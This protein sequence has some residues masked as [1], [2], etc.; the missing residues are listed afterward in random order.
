MQSSRLLPQQI[1]N[2]VH[3]EWVSSVILTCTNN[4][5]FKNVNQQPVLFCYMA[6]IFKNVFSSDKNALK[7]FHLYCQYPK[8]N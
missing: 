2:N 7:I 6:N 4:K 1:T 5:D 8:I 3:F